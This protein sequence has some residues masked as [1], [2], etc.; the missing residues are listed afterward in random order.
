MSLPIREGPLAR[1]GVIGTPGV[2]VT[3]FGGYVRRENVSYVRIDWLYVQAAA[4]T[5]LQLV[6]VAALADVGASAPLVVN[7]SASASLTSGVSAFRACQPVPI[8]PATGRPFLL[9]IRNKSVNTNL[10]VWVTWSDVEGI[11]G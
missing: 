8:N 10:N 6:L 11:V 3:D 4:E 5:P 9:V 2:V 7:F 1:N